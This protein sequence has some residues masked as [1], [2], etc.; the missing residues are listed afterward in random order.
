MDASLSCLLH[1]E[2]QAL[3]WRWFRGLTGPPA[4]SYFPIDH[5][6]LVDVN[7]RRVL[8]SLPLVSSPPPIRSKVYRRRS[9]EPIC[10]MFSSLRFFPPSDR[11]SQRLSIPSLTLP[12]L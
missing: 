5:I 4:Q 2:D 11:F 9:M 6:S 1:R 7:S 8:K 3:K 12:C 10:I